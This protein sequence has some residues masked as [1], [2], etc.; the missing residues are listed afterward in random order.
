[1]CVNEMEQRVMQGEFL[2]RDDALTLY[3]EA[4]T[5]ALCEA[6]DRIRKTFC[7]NVF[8]L[9]TIINGKSGRCSENCKF[10]A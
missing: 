4:E 9:C 10:C 5:E 3:F 2:T 6:A 1:M 7:G 8:D